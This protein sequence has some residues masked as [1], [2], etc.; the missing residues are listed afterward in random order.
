MGFSS[1]SSKGFRRRRQP[2]PHSWRPFPAEDWFAAGP[3]LGGRQKLGAAKIGVKRIGMAFYASEM[4]EHS[5]IW[6]FNVFSPFQLITPN[7]CS[8]CVLLKSR[9]GVG[10][11]PGVDRFW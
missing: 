5:Q 7:C 3:A 1:G 11:G 2:F 6:M 4:N 9:W 8:D 10:L